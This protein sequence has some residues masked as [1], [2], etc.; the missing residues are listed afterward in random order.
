MLFKSDG[1]ELSINRNIDLSRDDLVGGELMA[2]HSDFDGLIPGQLERR[3]ACRLQTQ[4]VQILLAADIGSRD[5]EIGRTV[6]VSASTAY[7]TQRRIVEGNLDRA[8]CHAQ[9]ARRLEAL[10]AGAAGR[11]DGQ[12]NPIMTA[13][14]A[15]PSAGGCR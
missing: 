5:D 3:Q 9:T 2:R 7:R 10:D 11:R 15:R 12:A 13:C 8:F 14:Q 1:K 6:G 4:R